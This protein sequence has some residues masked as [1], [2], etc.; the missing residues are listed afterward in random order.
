V[1]WGKFVS[2]MAVPAQRTGK[3]ENEP[4]QERKRLFLLRTVKDILSRRDIRMQLLSPWGLCFHHYSAIL[5]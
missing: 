5:G 1:Q 3:P 4:S 2:S